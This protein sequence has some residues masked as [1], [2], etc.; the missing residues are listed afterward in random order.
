[1]TRPA[2]EFFDIWAADAERTKPEYDPDVPTIWKGDRIPRPGKG[3][4]PNMP[5]VAVDA[6]GCSF[7][8]DPVQHQVL[9]SRC[10]RHR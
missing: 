9:S 3:P 2:E 5:A 10:P 6:P 4:R 8:P 7:N 1:M